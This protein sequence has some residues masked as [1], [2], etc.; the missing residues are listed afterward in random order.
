MN[1]LPRTALLLLGLIGLSLYSCKKDD[2]SD[3]YADLKQSIKENYANMAYQEYKDTYDAAVTLRTAINTFVVTPNQTNLDAARQAWRDARE[4]YAQTEAFRFSNG[5]IDDADGPEGL[6]NAWPLDEGYIDYVTGNATTGIINDTTIT[7]DAA[8]LETLNE[9]GGE[10]NIAVGYHAIEFLL[11]GQDDPNTALETPGNRPYTDYVTDGSGTAAHQDRR[12][13]YLQLLA[14]LLVDNL[15]SMV[16]EWDAAG[17][18]NYRVTF[19]AMDNDEA[20]SN[21]LTGLGVLSKGELAGERIFVA[22][23]NQDQEDEQSCFSDNTHRDIIQDA[24][25][26]RNVYTGTYVGTVTVSGASLSELVEAVDPTLNQELLTMMNNS[27][28]NTEAIYAPFDH[29]LTMSSERP[30]ILTTVQ[31]L[32]AQGDKIVEVATALGLSISNELPE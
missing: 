15:E 2:D 9:Q 20:L 30:Q 32:Q 6:L 25:G 3:P 27:V 18:S 10:T 31:G 21:I 7:I 11:W 4:Y 19:L 12:G 22:Y 16:D 1:N 14:D 23:D 26:V 28:T 24:V 29:A 17:A 13:A 8:T 5:P